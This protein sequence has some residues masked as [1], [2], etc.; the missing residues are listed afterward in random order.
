[1][2]KTLCSLAVMTTLCGMAHAQSNVTLYGLLDTGLVK[3]TGSDLNMSQWNSSR[4]G[5]K[6]TEDLGNGYQATFQLEKRYFVNNGTINGTEWEGASNVGLS[7]PFGSVRLGR[8]NELETESF[9]RLDPFNEEG[10]ASMLLSTLH[11]NRISNTIRYDSPVY[12]NFSV[13]ASYTLGTNTDRDSRD[14]Y[15][16]LLKTNGADNDG[17][18]VSLNYDNGPILLLANF[19]RLS[20]S[21]NS[22]IWSLGGQ[23]RFGPF[24]TSL[25][26]EQTRDNGWKPHATGSSYANKYEGVRSR[27]DNYILS[28]EYATGPHKVAAAFYYM[29][30][31]DIRRESAVRTTACFWATMIPAM[32]AN[33]ASVIFTASPNGP[34]C[35]DNWHI[36]TSRTK[37]WHAFSVA[38]PSAATA[39]PAYPSVSTI[40]SDA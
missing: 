29:K 5:F 34:P 33:T 14:S 21:D 23:Y 26:Y 16:N 13:N 25:G 37:P 36:P 7:G 40:F 19:S 38:K 2:N 35:M 6:G 27:Q 3:E 20:D 12:R 11:F 31:R 15:G 17:F 18:A 39:S 32:P 30:I 10:I 1:M 9:R 28:G 22:F 4:I 24:K 8:V